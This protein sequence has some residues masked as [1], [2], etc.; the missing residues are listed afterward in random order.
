M[1]CCSC[2]QMAIVLDANLLV[3][4]YRREASVGA[5]EHRIMVGLAEGDQA[6]AIP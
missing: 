2:V 3:Y 1:A 4:A 5:E 6:W